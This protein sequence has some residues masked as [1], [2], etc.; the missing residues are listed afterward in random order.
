MKIK[1]LIVFSVTLVALLSFAGLS[2]SQQKLNS[3]MGETFPRSG[4]KST[5]K[6]ASKEVTKAREDTS[7]PEHLRINRLHKPLPESHQPPVSDGLH[8]STLDAVQNEI[9]PPAEGMEGLSPDF[10][11]NKVDWVKSTSKWRNKTG[12]KNI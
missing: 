1:R 4:V 9:L 12:Y 8:D 10:Y 3:G 7:L 11:G 5:F 2:Y 6:P